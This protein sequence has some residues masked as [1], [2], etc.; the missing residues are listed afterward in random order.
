MLKIGALLMAIGLII[1][2]LAISGRIARVKEVRK[3]LARL[4]RSA[5]NG[6]PKVYNKLLIQDLPNP[7]QRYFEYALVD[8]QN[9]IQYAQLRHT[10]YFRQKPTQKWSPIT[11]EEYFTINPPGFFWLGKIPWVS[12]VDQYIEGKGNLKVKL[13]SVI[14]VVNA[15][16]EATNQGE[17]LRWLAEAVWYPTALL[18]SETLAWEA[19][20][21]HSAKIIYNDKHVKAEGVFHFNK[22][23]QITH[24]TT[25]RYM[26]DERLEGWTTHCKDYRL[27]HG[28]QVPFYAEVSW[29]L[30]EGDFCYAKFQVEDLQYDVLSKQD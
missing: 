28:M 29:N 30:T 20:D 23:G 10:G 25:Y 17:F 21:D 2:T 19:I 16:G 15:A 8:G 14:P 5:D 13:L 6:S 3:G 27:I 1:A 26:D 18:P 11:G 9:Y 7:V 4:Q 24:F 22:V 12:A